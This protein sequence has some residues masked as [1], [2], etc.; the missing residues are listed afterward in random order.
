MTH[1]VNIVC[2]KFCRFILRVLCA[3]ELLKQRL[4]T[5][6][7]PFNYR[8]LTHN[9]STSQFSFTYSARLRGS[10][11]AKGNTTVKGHSV[12]DEAYCMHHP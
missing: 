4:E 10:T 3:C 7:E 12:T 11:G 2:S 6:K 8:T 9:S 5:P 1:A